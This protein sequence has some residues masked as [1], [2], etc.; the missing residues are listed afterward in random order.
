MTWLSPCLQDKEL[1]M[2][3]AAYRLI[4]AQTDLVERTY[5]LSMSMRQHSA[6]P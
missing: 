3:S 4:R 6:A 2:K 1:P 5:A